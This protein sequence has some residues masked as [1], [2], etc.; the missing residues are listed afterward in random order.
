MC[1]QC[2]KYNPRCNARSPTSA[3]LPTLGHP[4]SELPVMTPGN[5]PQ[6]ISPVSTVSSSCFGRISRRCTRRPRS[7]RAPR[8]DR[9][10]L[11]GALNPASLTARRP[12]DT[13]DSGTFPPDSRL[14]SSPRPSQSRTTRRGRG[15]RRPAAH[16]GRRRIGQDPR[17][18]PSHRLAHPG[19]KRRARR[20]PG[21]HLHQQGR[22]RNGRARQSAAGPLV[23]RQAARSP[24]STRSACASFAATS[25]CSRSAARASRAPSPSSTRTI[26]GAWSS[27]S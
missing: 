17:H 6:N 8:R 23:A 19:K 12:N 16:P 11:F 27:R 10:N 18:H 21:R 24:P 4:S 1:S 14:A 9:L 26:S 2:D 15:H 13:L 3:Y 5:S 22:R 25:K 20:D 7:C